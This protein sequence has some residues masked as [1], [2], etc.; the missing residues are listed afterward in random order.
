[1]SITYYKYQ[2]IDKPKWDNCITH[3]DNGLLYAQSFYLDAMAANWDALVL[4]DYEAVMPLCWKK[5]FGIRYLYQPPFIQQM[6]IFF[7]N[8]LTRE[9]QSA[10]IQLARQKFRFAEI[11]LNYLNDPQ[12]P[13]PGIQTGQR[14]NFTLSLD[15][16]YEQLYENYD[17]A[18]TK[19]LRRIK[20]FE[21]L[22][23]SSVNY[24]RTIAWYKLLYGSRLPFF[25]GKSYAAFENVCKKLFKENNV[26]IRHARSTEN[27]LLASVILLRDEKRLYNVI[28][29]ISTEGKKLEANYF[30][31]DRII[32]EFADT[33]VMLDFE[34][35][36]VEGIAAFY[37]KFNPGNQPY[38]FIR[39]NNLPS[40]IKIF[41][42]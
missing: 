8:P 4:N 30:L 37:K 32:H 35:S 16:T 6:G 28:S 19:S 21:I 34:G 13:D 12:L 11:T 25:P 20:K 1:M 29:C 3:A 27:K 31:Y 40:Y 9:Q 5:K 23:V 33:A 7:T 26:I 14:N 36:D 42:R 2:D 41:K 10:F 39:Y 24:Q 18:F 22:Y 17:P 38:P 15:R